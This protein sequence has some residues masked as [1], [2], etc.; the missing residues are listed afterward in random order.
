MLPMDS[1][2]VCSQVDDDDDDVKSR[3]SRNY[4]IHVPRQPL[5]ALL[6]S[7]LDDGT[8]RWGHELRQVSRRAADGRFDLD[9]KGEGSGRYEATVVVAA[10]GVHSACRRGLSSSASP[11][12]MDRWPRLTDSITAA[13]LMVSLR[14]TGAR[15]LGGS[16]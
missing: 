1:E 7:R 9:F 10:D 13:S 11:S 5:R 12:S 4:A 6:L 15:G 16:S 8:V 14:S 2:V 3:N